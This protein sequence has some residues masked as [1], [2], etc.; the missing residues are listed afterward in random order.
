[1][2]KH[3]TYIE[4]K[5]V[6]KLVKFCAE[7][8]RLFL[9][10]L[11]SGDKKSPYHKAQGLTE[12]EDAIREA[13][14]QFCKNSDLFSKDRLVKNGQNFEQAVKFPVRIEVRR[15]PGIDGAAQIAVRLRF[16]Q[17]I[18]RPNKYWK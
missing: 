1:M 16:L 15:S 17:K 2:S 3:S 6:Q 7:E 11:A 10:F 14:E 5:D 13:A 4:E 8:L 18:K 9:G 12:I